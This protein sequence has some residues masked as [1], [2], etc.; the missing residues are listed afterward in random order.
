MLQGAGA[1]VGLTLFNLL[2][3]WPAGA[4]TWMLVPVL[5]VGALGGAMGGGVWY[6]TDDP[7]SRGGWRKTLANVTS[8]LA[9]GLFVFGAL[10][11]ALAFLAP[12]A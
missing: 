4:Q 9:Y 12:G 10:L 1:V 5:A 7:R 2:F 3:R 6:A 11:V 8:L